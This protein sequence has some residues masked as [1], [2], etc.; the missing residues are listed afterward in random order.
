MKDKRYQLAYDI[1]SRHG[2]QSGAGF[3]DGEFLSGW[4]ALRFLNKPDI[5]ITHFQNLAKGVTLP[6][7]VARGWYWS[8]RAEE[9]LQHPNEAIAHYRKAAENAETFYGQLALAR[10]EDAPVLKLSKAVQAPH[11]RGS[12][13]V[14]RDERVGVIRILSQAKDRPWR[15]SLPCGWRTISRPMRRSSSCSRN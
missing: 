14:R 4:I 1:A 11:A 8:G 13:R 7:S 10:I 9:A 6:I 5:A 15:G 3:A 2:L 12:S